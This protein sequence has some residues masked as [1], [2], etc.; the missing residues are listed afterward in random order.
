MKDKDD[1]WGNA[2]MNNRV[3]CAR[4]DDENGCC[5]YVND[6]YP[7]SPGEDIMMDSFVESLQPGEYI[8]PN[9][10]CPF[11]KAYKRKT[12]EDTGPYHAGFE[13]ATKK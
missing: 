2:H 13:H 4:F 11:F 3:N 10:N 5:D 8:C 6:E 7:L 1:W 12:K 9:R